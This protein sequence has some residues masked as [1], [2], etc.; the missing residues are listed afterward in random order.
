MKYLYTFLIL[1]VIGC[2]LAIKSAN[3]VNKERERT[4]PVPDN[5]SNYKDFDVHIIEKDGHKFAVARSYHG[6]SIIEIK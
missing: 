4:H 5:T 2:V 3:K 6:L 1:L